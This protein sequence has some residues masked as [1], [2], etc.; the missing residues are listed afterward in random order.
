MLFFSLYFLEEIY[1]ILTSPLGSS[2]SSLDHSVEEG[3]I[4]PFDPPPKSKS[5]SHKRS[6]SDNLDIEER[7]T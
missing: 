7:K 1:K 5:K 3:D 4:S 6:K 2:D